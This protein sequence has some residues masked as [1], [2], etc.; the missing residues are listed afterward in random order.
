MQQK[1]RPKRWMEAVAKAREGIDA[2]VELVE[3]Y[4][5]WRDNLPENLDCSPLAEK[6]DAIIDL[7]IEDIRDQLEEADGADLPLGFGRD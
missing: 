2:L 5:E 4:Q 1:S 6:L 3:E 7:G